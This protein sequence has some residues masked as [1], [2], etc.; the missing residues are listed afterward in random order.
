MCKFKKELYIKKTITKDLEDLKIP[1]G[2]RVI[3]NSKV[4]TIIKLSVNNS[5][6]NASTQ[7]N[8]TAL[9]QA[10]SLV[11]AFDGLNI[12][13]I[14]QNSQ[15]NQAG[16]NLSN[17]TRERNGDDITSD[18]DFSS[19]D[20]SLHDDDSSD[21][22]SSLILPACESFEYIIHHGAKTLVYKGNLYSLNRKNKG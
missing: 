20:V 19:D 15:D 7:P 4:E 12:D 18:N 17:N 16:E 5:Q 13:R 1:F 2:P 11:K 3:I 10:P 9:S 21:D 8:S 6:N 22:D 14:V